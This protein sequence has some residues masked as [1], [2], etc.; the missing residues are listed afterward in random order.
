MA[1]Y[2]RERR[3]DEDKREMISETVI[4]RRGNDETLWSLDPRYCFHVGWAMGPRTRNLSTESASLSSRHSSTRMSAEM[5][6]LI[7]EIHRR[8]TSGY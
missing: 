3:K 2:K 4:L 7:K 5:M 8:C 1:A 6:E